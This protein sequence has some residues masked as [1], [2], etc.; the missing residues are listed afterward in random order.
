MPPFF[1]NELPHTA[2]GKLH[3]LKLPE[4]FP[5]HVLPSLHTSRR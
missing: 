2:V 3:K 1:V 5:Q 4:M